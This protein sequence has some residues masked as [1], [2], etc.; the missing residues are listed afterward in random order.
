LQLNTGTSATLRAIISPQYG[1]GADPARELGA[2]YS[3]L[4][5][6]F[7]GTVEGYL[8]T[9]TVNDDFRQIALIRNPKLANGTAAIQSIYP[10]YTKM[11]VENRTTFAADANLVVDDTDFTST[12][13]FYD[14]AE[15][16]LY[17]N[18]VQGDANTILTLPIKQEN[19][20]AIYAQVY[21][22]EKPSINIA[23]GEILYIE[24]RA[25]VTRDADQTET[26]KIVIE[27]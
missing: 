16:V 27:F 25:A 6:D 11:F 20:A 13:L 21:T 10:M 1:H 9:P 12:V 4:S 3:M 17:V 2:S 23:S 26:A 15:D 14:T 18:N 24:N 8:P 22:V 5:V 19:D 7:D